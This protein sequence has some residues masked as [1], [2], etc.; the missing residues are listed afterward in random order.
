[1][2]PREQLISGLGTNQQTRL[3]SQE[4][5][6]VPRVHT[7]AALRL[8]Q[9]TAPIVLRV[10]QQLAPIINQVTRGGRKHKEHLT[11]VNITVN[12]AAPTR[13][14]RSKAAPP[15]SSTRASTEVSTKEARLLRPTVSTQS[16]MRTRNAAEIE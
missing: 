4:A 3:V 1:M 14:M 10:E 13:I 2:A 12:N 16:K 15:L 9:R 8:Q 11:A 7:E 5:Q 6:Q